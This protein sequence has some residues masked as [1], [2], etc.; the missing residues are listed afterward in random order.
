MTASKK[1]LIT[2]SDGFLGRH[3]TPVL[4]ADE[5]FEVQTVVHE[6]FDLRLQAD[7]KTM[8]DRFKPDLVLHLAA[9][10][11]GII[12]NKKYAADYFY[13]NLL[14]GTIA[15]DAAYKAGVDKYITFMGG[16]S[17]PASASSPIGEEE[18]WN[19]YPQPESSEIFSA[20]SLFD[21]FSDSSPT[22]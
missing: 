22:L 17:Y 14:L 18:M 16:C 10:V 8:L 9:K 15:L 21:L 2:G 11:G 13:D 5:A 7:A 6:N 4:E 19:G 12:S 20:N 3:I 1:I